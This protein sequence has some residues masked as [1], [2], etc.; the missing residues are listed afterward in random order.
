[1]A[2]WR[3][4]T[5]RFILF[6]SGVILAAIA[7]SIFEQTFKVSEAF[8]IALTVLTA[9][10]GLFFFGMSTQRIATF[11]NANHHGPTTLTDE[12][13]SLATPQSPTQLYAPGPKTCP[14][15]LLKPA[16]R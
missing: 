6:I 11:S 7:T 3:K 10:G 16:S 14:V 4:N 12:M 5:E 15:G 8:L 1:M 2:Q 9:L 13:A